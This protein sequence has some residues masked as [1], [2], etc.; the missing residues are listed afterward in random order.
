MPSSSTASSTPFQAV[1]LNDLSSIPPVSVTWQ[2]LN[3]DSP[4]PVPQAD[5]KREATKIIANNRD[6][7]FDIKGFLLQNF[8]FRDFAEWWN[9]AIQ[10]SVS[11]A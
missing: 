5:N 3:V 6:S 1:A 7:F 9:R 2:A 4:P 8:E 11:L 10:P